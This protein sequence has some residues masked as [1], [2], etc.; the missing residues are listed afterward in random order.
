[1]T[2]MRFSTDGLTGTVTI[3]P[4][5]N[6]GRREALVSV[7]ADG[8]SAEYTCDLRE[9]ELRQFLRDLEAALNDLGHDRNIEFRTLERAI[10]L[11]LKLDK[12]G[13]VEGSY[14]FARDWRG[15]R[16]CGSFS[17]DQTHLVGW[18]HELKAVLGGN[19]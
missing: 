14:E 9:D 8:F 19:P 2:I 11:S 10:E 4:Q 17:A 1:M 7:R 6:G 16:M 18:V 12:R 3:S 13:H 5:N 15:P